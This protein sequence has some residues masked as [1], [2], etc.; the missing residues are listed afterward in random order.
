[1]HIKDCSISGTITILLM[2]NSF[3]N[4]ELIFSQQNNLKVK[5]Y[6]N[7]LKLINIF[8]NTLSLPISF[9]LEKG[10]NA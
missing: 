7:F 3:T 2:T 5:I 9:S 6:Y 8:T 10:V 4:L 1:M